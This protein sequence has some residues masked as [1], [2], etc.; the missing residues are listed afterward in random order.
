MKIKEM[1][2]K[3]TDGKKEIRTVKE[4]IFEEE[5]VQCAMCCKFNLYTE[6]RKVDLNWIEVKDFSIYPLRGI[7][8]NYGTSLFFCGKKCF[9]KA[10]TKEYDARMSEEKRN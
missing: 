10:M 7:G 3:Q 2:D 1:L 6:S 9:I 4:V 5:K 8:R